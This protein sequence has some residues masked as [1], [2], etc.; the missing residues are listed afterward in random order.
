MEHR[1][2]LA[3]E[4]FR[5][6]ARAE[7]RTWPDLQWNGEINN[8]DV[9]SRP[10]NDEQFMIDGPCEAGPRPMWGNICV[11]CAQKYSP[12]IGWGKA[13]LYEKNENDVWKLIS[14]GPVA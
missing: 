10:M 4:H 11:T 3:N 13:Q 7:K 6:I 14:G 8:C 2:Q 9:C 12:K 5:K 1:H